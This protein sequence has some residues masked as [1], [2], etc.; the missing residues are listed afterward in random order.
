MRRLAVLSVL[1]LAFACAQ[2]AP[3]PEKGPEEKPEPPKVEAKAEEK[4]EAPKVERTPS[5]PGAQV[6]FKSPADGAK[7]KS[8]VKLEFGIEVMSVAKAGDSTEGTGHHHLIVDAGMPALDAPI[9]AN[10]N[11]IHFG[12]GSTSKELELEPGEHTLQL[13]LGDHFHVPHEPP[14][15]SEVITITVE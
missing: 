12:D 14:V 5:L 1:T 4:P 6:F 2:T 9:P 13:L 7:V 11:Y 3:E 10:D 15:S 8:P